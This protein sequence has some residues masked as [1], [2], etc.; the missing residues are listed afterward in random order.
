MTGQSIG[1][2]SAE[3]SGFRG[4]VRTRRWT[5][6]TSPPPAEAGMRAPGCATA[7]STPG[8]TPQP[9]V[10]YCAR[11]VR[12]A[13]HSSTTIDTATGEVLGHVLLGRRAA[14]GAVPGLWEPP[15]RRL[16]GLFAD[17]RPGHVR[18]DPRRPGR[19][20]DRPRQ[21]ADNPLLFVTLT[22][23]SFGHVHGPRPHAGQP[24]RWSVPT[25]RPAAAVRATGGRS[26][27]WPSTARTTRSNG[28]PL[29]PD[30][31]DWDSAVV[32]QW[33]APELWRRTTI[34]L[35]RALAAVARGA[36]DS[37]CEQ[38]ASLQYA[39][40]AEYQARGLIHFHALIRLDGPDGPGLTRPAG[41][42]PAAPRRR[43]GGRAVDL[44]R[45]G[46]RR[47]R[48]GPGAG[49]GQAARRPRGPRRPPHRRPDRAADA[50]AGR[51]LP[52]EV[53]H[54]GRQQHPRPGQPRPAPD[55]ARPRPAANL[56]AHGP[57]A[58]DPADRRTCCWASGRTCSASAATSPPSPAATRSPSARSAGP[59]TGSSTS[60]P[61]RDAPGEPLD[62]R[63]LEARLLA[64]DEETT[65]VI[66]SW[67]YQGTGW[68][69]PG[70]EALAL[71]AAARAREYDQWRA[72]AA[73]QAA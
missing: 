58:H 5:C 13:G 7:P 32:W 38:V 43:P 67:A 52:G 26:A 71:A 25:P 29:C 31:Y 16:P 28:S 6:P 4:S 66:G 45:P 17:L 11:P 18:D 33:W 9:A 41:R 22:A 21:V 44:H 10:G 14:R 62:T 60:P 53:R 19:R 54:Q 50:R 12:L 42:R 49:V 57:G 30:C 61:R 1:K 63:D 69:R 34:A 68:T 59:G 35:R 56:A 24:D 51:R 55:P 47:R 70:D 3:A 46:R 72:A 64:D 40:V 8:P 37:G 15:R 73:Q 2:A 27:A 39:K 23:P 65:L 20:Q 48:R 36:G